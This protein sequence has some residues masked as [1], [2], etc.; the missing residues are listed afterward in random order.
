MN[1]RGPTGWTVAVV[2]TL[3]SCVAG[4]CAG[5][6]VIHAERVVDT[7]TS[8]PSGAGDFTSFGA[9][10]LSD[11]GTAFFGTG[12]GGQEGIYRRHRPTASDPFPD[13]PNAVA[14]LN[15]PVSNGTGN[16]LHFNHGG[17]YTPPGQM[18][19]AENVAFYGAGSN[20]QQGMYAS[21][22]G[23]LERVADTNT[24]IPGDTGNFE[25][26]PGSPSIS[27]GIVAFA[28]RD[29][30]RTKE[31]VY[32]L[33][34]TLQAIA[35]KNTSIPEGTGNFESFSPAPVISGVDVAFV[36]GGSGGQQGVYRVMHDF[37]PS[38]FTTRLADRATAIPGGTGTFTG[39][40]DNIAISETGVAFIGSGS[41]GQQ[42]VYV[43]PWPGPMAPPMPNI[44]LPL[45]IVDT[46]TVIPGGTGTFTEFLAVGI[47]S[48]DIAFLGSGS[49][50][51]SG[52]FDYRDGSLLSLVNVGDTLDGKTITGVSFT[53]GGLFEDTIAFGAFFADGSQ[54]I[55][56]MNV[57]EPTSFVLLAL[58][59]LLL[60]M[61]WLRRERYS[62]SDQRFGPSI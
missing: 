25:V 2:L 45:R 39:F 27:G 8:I 15:A 58:G 31:G 46:S 20:S 62:V 5:A 57:P 26:F 34:G 19:S 37:L 60:G 7:A 32:V 4:R 40:A 14:D 48:T 30:L 29:S 9:P 18:I 52:I 41:G 23:T 35:D 1:A 3:L 50:G 51:Q 6:E 43:S 55:Y 17:I 61:Q 11:V 24:P 47:S 44:P 42:G 13:P 33:D 16:F 53:G 12:S 22:N 21:I 28:G 38:G 49:S 36:G 54:G 56:V 10:G 59:S